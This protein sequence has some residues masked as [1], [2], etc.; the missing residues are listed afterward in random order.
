MSLKKE[1][2]HGWTQV[3]NAIIN[4]SEL[5]FKAKGLWVYI[6]SKIEGWDFAIWRIAQ[7]IKEGEKAISAGLKELV[8]FGYLEYQ[9]KVKDGK[10]AGQEYILRDEPRC[11]S[12][13]DTKQEA[14][15]ASGTQNGGY[16]NKTKLNKTELN[17]ILSNISEKNKQTIT[18]FFLNLENAFAIIKEF[19]PAEDNQKFNEV[20]SKI[21]I[22]NLSDNMVDWFIE[23]KG[24]NREIKDIVK[25]FKN[26][27]VKVPKSKFY[28]YVY[29]YTSST[30]NPN[31]GPTEGPMSEEEMFAFNEEQALKQLNKTK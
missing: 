5:S 9:P 10:L 21:I 6:N 3:P 25:T 29:G 14:P 19:Y 31:L 18:E 2:E 30:D 11:Q 15:K 1:F 17:N 13:G 26:W 27:L 20:Q 23:G 12:R 28:S 7:E 16:N 22:N 8:K 24:K 4:H